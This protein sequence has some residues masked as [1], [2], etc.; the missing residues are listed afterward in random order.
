MPWVSVETNICFDPV[1]EGA[2]AARFE[3][4]NPDWD[5]SCFTTGIIYTKVEH[6]KVVFK[7]NTEDKME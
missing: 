7:I 1:T 4:V 3:A 6:K 2:L 5:K